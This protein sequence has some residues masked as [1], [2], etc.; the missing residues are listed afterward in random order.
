MAAARSEQS[1]LGDS[2]QPEP[3]VVE[4]GGPH[5]HTTSEALV[6]DVWQDGDLVEVAVLLADG[7]GA[8]ARIAAVE[9][10][11]LDARTGDILLVS[12]AR[13]AAVSA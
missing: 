10:D 3:A 13:S 12:R 9:W 8:T 5:D 2:G 4:L 1:T 6:E 7:S 11:W